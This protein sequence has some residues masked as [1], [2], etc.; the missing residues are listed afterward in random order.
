MASELIDRD[1]TAHLATKA[2]V[3]AIEA[4]LPHLATK[5]D[6]QALRA[7]VGAVVAI[8]PH[9]ATK[10]EI[11]MMHT[12]IIK[13]IVGTATA[14]GGLSIALLGAMWAIVKFVHPG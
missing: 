13:W 2:Q 6:V 3:S 11:E 10:A 9:L 1:A 14:L 5:A 7:D 8:L 12:S 4:T